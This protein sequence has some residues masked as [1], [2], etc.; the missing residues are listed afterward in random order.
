[1]RLDTDIDLAARYEYW[2]WFSP[3][4][5]ATDRNRYDFFFT[6]SRLDM[7]LSNQHLNVFVQLQD[8]HMWGLPD[9]SISSPPA[10]PLGGGAIYFAHGQQ[11]DYH[12][13]A[14]R[15]AY[16]KS[17]RLF[18]KG[19]SFKIG[20]F[21]YTD[22]LEVTYSNKKLSWIKKMRVAE[23]LIGPFI[24]SSFWRSF[25]GM[26]LFLDT[27]PLNLTGMAT[28]PTQGGFENDT[29][30][31]IHDIDLA[32]LTLTLRYNTLIRNN[33]ARIFYFYYQDKRDVPKADN[34]PAGSDLDSGNIII[35]T[36][37]AHL[38]G[39]HPALTG[40][41]DWLFWGAYQ[42][43]RWG[44][45]DHQAW[46]LAV[47]FGYQFDHTRWRPWIRTG[48]AVG[49]GDADPNDGWHNTFYQLVPTSRKYALFPFYNMMNSED[50][51]IQAILKP[52]TKTTIRTDL[53]RLRL[54]D[55]SDRWYMGA[56]PTLESGRIF[57]YIGRPSF[58]DHDLGVLADITL[59]YHHSPHLWFTAYYGHVFGQ[60]VIKNIYPRDRDADY[61]YLEMGLR[62]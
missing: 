26:E 16:I 30:T 53:H 27:D 51:F 23:R 62:F 15:Q 49:S 36:I 60:D 10:G 44:R 55:A 46:A 1:M 2:K 4:K 6:R 9:K 8:V 22:G 59:I 56:G 43:G 21:D 39:I 3:K 58:G 17:N 45:L 48:Y 50:L 28:H 40:T 12:S 18:S 11:K 42:A 13:T 24:W 14:I 57:G 35:H 33:E 61:A 41:I 38:L 54:N 7:D 37:G 19:P 47:E 32:T 5:Q 34:T 31:T 52:S 25:D 29:Q 20:R